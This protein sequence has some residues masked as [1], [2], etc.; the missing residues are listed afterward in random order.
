[1]KRSIWLV[2]LVFS[3]APLFGQVD[4]I[5][6]AKE[7][8]AFHTMDSVS[9]PAAGQ[10]LLIGSSSFTIWK[11]VN[12]Y[13]PGYTILNRAFGGSTLADQIRYV[14][15]VVYPYN[16]RQILIYC[17][18]NDLASS[19]TVTAAVTIARLKTLFNLIRKKYPRTPIDFVAIKP[20]PSRQMIQA[21]VIEANEG[22]RKFLAQ[23]KR[24][25]FIDVYKEMVDDEG[26]SRPELFGEDMLHMNKDGY[27]IWQRSIAPYL[28]K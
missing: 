18:E 3:F 17:G 4:E 11:D 12:E 22:I 14:D 26:K 10:I 15:K 24:T 8:A 2:I 5:P 9:M 16:P 28:I 23:K 19:D 7:V 21:K 6:Y 20:S 25:A 13:F 1:M 27:R